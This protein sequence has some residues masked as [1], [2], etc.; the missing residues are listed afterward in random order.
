MLERIGK[1]EVKEKIGEGGMGVVYKAY[2]P[3]MHRHVAIK[4][5]TAELEVEAEVRSRFLREAIAV[6]RLTHANIV[7]VHDVFEEGDGTYMVMEYLEG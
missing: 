4:T 2:D 5:F 7:T 6:G 1:F 3:L